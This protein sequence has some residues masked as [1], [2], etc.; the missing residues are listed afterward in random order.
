VVALSTFE[1]EVDGARVLVHAG[2]VFLSDGPV[3]EGHREVFLPVADYV[4]FHGTPPT[5]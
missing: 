1:A 2:D 3:V 5:P 4:Q